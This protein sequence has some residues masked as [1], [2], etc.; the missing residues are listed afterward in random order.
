M[1]DCK[2]GLVIVSRAGLPRFDFHVPYF[3]QDSPFCDISRLEIISK[4]TPRN[5]R[6][7]QSISNKKL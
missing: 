3:S 6:A 7:A 4:K 2:Q 1:A 5:F